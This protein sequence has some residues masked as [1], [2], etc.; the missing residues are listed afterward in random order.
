MQATGCTG[1]GIRRREVRRG[2]AHTQILLHE[3]PY[4]PRQRRNGLDG[5][6]IPIKPQPPRMERVALEAKARLVL[7]GPALGNEFY[8]ERRV[9]AVNFVAD[10][11]TVD[12]REMNA[13]LMEAA[14]M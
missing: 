5:R 8:I 6:A 11:R 3:L 1:L 2:F 14:G 9:G 7:G 4:V 12:V 10:Q 13:Q